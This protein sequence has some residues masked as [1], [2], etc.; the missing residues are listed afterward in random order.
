MKTKLMPALL[1]VALI[2]LTPVKS[3]Q[4]VPVYVS[5]D[6]LIEELQGDAMTMRVYANMFKGNSFIPL[7][8]YFNARADA[9]DD[10]V[11]RVKWLARYN[12]P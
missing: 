6:T 2:T 12:T 4:Q 7:N 11:L 1:I 5:A 8:A 9:L 10:A 3:H